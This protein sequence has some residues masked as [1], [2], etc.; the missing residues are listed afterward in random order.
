MAGWKRKWSI[1]GRVRR[2]GLVVG[3]ATV[4][5]VVAGVATGPVGGFTAASAVASA[6]AAIVSLWR[7]DHRDLER[8]ADQVDSHQA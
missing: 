6:A 5:G 1:S 8:S 7:A 4:S 3:T 2:V